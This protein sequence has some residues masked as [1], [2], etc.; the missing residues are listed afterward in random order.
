MICSQWNQAIEQY[1]QTT[2]YKLVK[3]SRS[4]KIYGTNSSE[5]E[6]FLKTLAKFGN[7]IDSMTF[8]I[9][10]PDKSSE[11]VYLALSKALKNLPNLNQIHIRYD[12]SKI[13]SFP[14]TKNLDRSI[15]RNPCSNLPKLV[16]IFVYGLVDNRIVN[17]LLRRSKNVAKLEQRMPGFTSHSLDYSI[18]LPNLN[19]LDL[20]I[21]EDHIF[22]KLKQFGGNWKIK[23]FR[24]DFSGLMDENNWLDLFVMLGGNW[25]DCLQ[26]L[27]IILPKT[28]FNY[29][30]DG[31]I[32]N[33][34]KLTTYERLE[35]PLLRNIDIWSMG[36]I[37]L[38]FLLPSVNSLE[39]IFV[40]SGCDKSLLDNPNEIYID[41]MDRQIV[42]HLGSEREMHKSNIWIRFPKLK[43]V[44]CFRECVYRPAH[45]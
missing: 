1:Y 16:Y 41:S 33:L 10:Y 22:Q 9:D 23:K 29:T 27:S 31:V 32:E 20:T 2:N 13:S 38:D 43:W 5:L 21:R 24:G 4:F 19:V 3:K 15:K 18:N 26:I 45:L 34:L 36:P 8:H 25:L 42:E 37:S 14:K 35:L 7:G 39:S 40:F 6:S 28:S 44:N 11:S 12:Q 17:E 30:K